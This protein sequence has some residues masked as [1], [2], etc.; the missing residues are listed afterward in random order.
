MPR[1]PSPPPA[2]RV[3]SRRSEP[4]VDRRLAVIVPVLNE[5]RVLP[6][7]LDAL[8]AQ[9]G[10]RLHS[11]V[12]D[13]GSEDGSTRIA[14]AHGAEVLRTPPGRGR[15]MNHGADAARADWLLFLHADSQLDHRRQLAE[16]LDLMQT[17]AVGDLAV[18]GHW[19][20]RFQRSQ[21]G[22][23]YFFRYLEG[24]TASQRPYSIHGDQGLLIHRD[25]F[26]ALGGFDTGLPIF[27]DD[28]LAADIFATGRWLL[29]P[30]RLST[31]ARRFE[32]E[33][34]AARYALMAL[35]VVAEAGGLHAYLREVPGLYREQARTE[36]LRLRPFLAA[37]RDH[38]ARQP[39]AKQTFFWE[40]VGA[41]LCDNAWQLAY[42]LDQLGGAGLEGPLLRAH[43][44]WLAP[45]LAEPAARRL[46][47]RLARGLLKP[48]GQTWRSAARADAADGGP[49]A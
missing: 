33:G 30:G 29:L 7:L 38:L 6:A 31:S 45:W 41:L 25:Y 20:L 2:S 22:R 19:Q 17:A 11:I 23:D 15:Q 39:A 18:A 4:P 1:P 40:A 32:S 10:L 26:Q 48:L 49:L 27:E 3:G 46:A 34:P 9:Q 44:R 14:K 42:G 24:K 43:D 5:A 47:S 16:A 37:L 21:P 36:R 8:N 12:V 35:M 13:G 28:R